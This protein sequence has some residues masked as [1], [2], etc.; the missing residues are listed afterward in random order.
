[1]ATCAV[2]VHCC[3]LVDFPWIAVGSA[4]GG[5]EIVVGV[6]E[7]PATGSFLSL[8]VLDPD[9]PGP[10]AEALPRFSPAISGSSFGTTH[11]RIDLM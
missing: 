10:S 6:D 5:L 9:C 2:I 3:S 4:S 8:L 11:L 7:G 1:M